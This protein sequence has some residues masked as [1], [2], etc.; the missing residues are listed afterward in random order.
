MA[1]EERIATVHGRAADRVFDQVRIHVDMTV[2]QK[3]AKAI[4]T[5]QYIGHGFSEIGFARHTAC[6]CFQPCEE[7][8]DQRP[9]AFLP[10]F[11]SAFRILAA[12]FAFDLVERSNA[13]QR[14]V[15]DI[16]AKSIIPRSGLPQDVNLRILSYEIVIWK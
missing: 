6:L 2:V 3:E 16:R 15:H 9:G 8:I 4:L 14:L 7:G 12:D 10:G 13:H 1:G 11:S 5:F